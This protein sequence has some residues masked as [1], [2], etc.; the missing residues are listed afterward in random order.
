MGKNLSAASVK[1]L[2]S[3]LPSDLKTWIMIPKILLESSSGPTPHRRYSP[4]STPPPLMKDWEPPNCL[5]SQ[6]IWDT[7]AQVGGSRWE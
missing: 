4:E 2:G 7:C 3:F 5:K 1:K 6:R